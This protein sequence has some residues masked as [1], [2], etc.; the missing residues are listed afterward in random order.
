MRKVVFNMTMS[1][2]GFVAGPNDNPDNG[3]G[4][5]GEALFKWYFSGDTEISVGSGS[6]V[7]KVS[8]QSAKILKEAIA[9]YGAGVWGRRTFDIA[10]AWGGHPPGSPCFIVTHSVPHEWVHEGSPFTFVTDG[11][12]SA[13]RQARKAAGDKDVVVCTAS[14]LQQCL[15]AGLMDEIHVDIA[16][17]LL[18]NGVRLFDHLNIHPTELQCI[19]VVEAPGVTHLGFRVVK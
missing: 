17:L 3:L 4:D 2:D 5:G 12:E 13:I 7:L 14:I 15:N 16:P 11:I 19:R 9:T 18:G 1:L 10:R 6:P 8:P